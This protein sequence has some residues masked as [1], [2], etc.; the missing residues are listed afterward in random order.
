M[1]LWFIVIGVMGAVGI[2]RAPAILA[3][4][5]PMPAITYLWHAG[6]SPSWSSGAPSSP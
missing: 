6:R 1:L 3:A 5:S 2:A 4:L